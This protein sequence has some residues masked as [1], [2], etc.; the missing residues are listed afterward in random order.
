MAKTLSTE[1]IM[2]IAKQTSLG[3]A[4]LA[5]SEYTR[6][7]LTDVLRERSIN[8]TQYRLLLCLI[9]T[10]HEET[11]LSEL[12][13][14]VS[15]TSS[16]AGQ[17]LTPLE[18]LG[19]V[20]R[21]RPAG[22]GRERAVVLTPAGREFVDETEVVLRQT[23]WDRFEPHAPDHR[24]TLIRG[25]REGS[26]IGELWRDSA[27]ADALV[28]SSSL[29]AAD[30]AARAVEASLREACRLTLNEARVLQRLAEIGEPMRGVD[31]AEQLAVSPATA[32]RA[33]QR[34]E[35]RGM[36]ERLAT[37]KNAQAVFLAPTDLGRNAQKTVLTTLDS[38]GHAIYGAEEKG[39][40]PFID[41]IRRG[42]SV[43]AD[44]LEG[45]RHRELLE[46]LK[47][48]H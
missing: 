11:P 4:R 31:L 28:A 39:E 26:A 1:Q 16:A 21:V 12:A 8:P 14:R 6:A 9:D 40:M 20:R 23:L 36:V 41:A 30:V 33:A 10:A 18:N 19:Y 25:L 34:L 5:T 7:V 43:R 42:F 35:K 46:S 24:E 22:D 15:M 2:Q 37:E 3:S 27:M 29:V 45:T 32:T 47:P 17:A 44:E 38:A 13:Q 48:A